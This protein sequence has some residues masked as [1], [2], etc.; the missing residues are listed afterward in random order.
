MKLFHYL[1]VIFTVLTISIYAQNGNSEE[2]EIKEL[3]DHIGYLASDELEGRKPGTEGIELA[4]EY[5]VEQL[6]LL[7]TRGITFFA[8]VVAGAQICS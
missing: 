8:S 7:C 1:T 5:I 3:K 4:A 2:I 6:E